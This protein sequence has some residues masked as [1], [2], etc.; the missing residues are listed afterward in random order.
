[1]GPWPLTHPYHSEISSILAGNSPSMLASTGTSAVPG[2]CAGGQKDGRL[3]A[4]QTCA[5][6]RYSMAYTCL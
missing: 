4:P 3:F 2:P 6:D 5:R 1:M